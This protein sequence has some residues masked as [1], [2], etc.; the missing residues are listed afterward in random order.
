MDFHS[1]HDHM[2]GATSRLNKGG[3]LKVV[4]GLNL[5]LVVVLAI[6]GYRYHSLVL[7]SAALHQF[8]DSAGVG[9]TLSALVLSLKPASSR[10]S[11]GLAR[12]E[13]LA[14]LIN[15]VALLATTVWIV[16][17]AAHRIEVPAVTSG[18]SVAELGVIGGVISLISF[19][20]LHEKTPSSLAIRINA[21]HFAADSLAW[22][23]TIASGLLIV[24]T[25]AKLIDPISSILVSTLVLLAT[26]KLVAQTVD[27]LL[28]A[29]PKDVK[30]SEIV[31]EILQQSDI[32]DVHH[33]HIWSLGSE[34]PAL[35]AHIVFTE[36]VDLHVA[37]VRTD[38][39]KGMLSEKFHIDHATI[40]IECHP[41]EAPTH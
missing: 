4:V 24:A 31:T 20:L 37:Q 17:E 21:L 35:S 27:V 13:V 38:A 23:V 25:G 28:E 11:Y 41:C 19:L 2:D 33:L 40:E 3:S 14:A 29:T 8:V 32:A 7:Y 18:A 22:L 15:G 1:E 10:H 6:G 39:I 9:I 12:L 36:S 26:W 16:I 30:P 34:T 5:V